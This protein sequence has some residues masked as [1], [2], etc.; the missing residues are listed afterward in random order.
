MKLH[1][2]YFSLNIIRMSR[3]RRMKWAGHIARTG[4]TR[5]AYKASARNPKRKGALR[6]PRHRSEGHIKAD[7]EEIRW[8]GVD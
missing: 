3:S 5:N 6:I 1:Y 2:L 8:K 4:E 7:V